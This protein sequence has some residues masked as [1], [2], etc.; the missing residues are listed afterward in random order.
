MSRNLFLVFFFYGSLLKIISVEARVKYVCTVGELLLTD[1][2]Y[3]YSVSKQASSTVGD[4]NM[5]GHTAQCVSGDQPDQ[6]LIVLLSQLPKRCLHACTTVLSLVLYPVNHYSHTCVHSSRQQSLRIRI[7]V[8]YRLLLRAVR[9][10]FQPFLC[11]I[12]ESSL[13]FTCCWDLV[14]L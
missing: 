10:A 12:R 3:I 1:N 7:A 2:V 6:K 8:P 5:S 13:T 9:R 11:L 14:P 4:L